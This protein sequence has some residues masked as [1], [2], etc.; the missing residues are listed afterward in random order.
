VPDPVSSASDAELR[1]HVERVLAPQYELEREI[2]RGGMGI[3]YRA[4][5]ARLKR[6]VAIKLLPPELAFRAE[7]RTRFLREAETAAQLSHPSIVPIHSVDEKEGLVFFVMAFVDGENLAHR[8]HARG[9]LPVEDVRRILREVAEALA[10]AHARGVVHRDIKPDNILLG[11]DGER[12]MVTDFGIARAVTEG[13]DSRLTA[14]GIAIGTPAFMSPEQSAGDREIDGRSDLYALGVVA[15]QMLTGQLP[16]TAASTPAMLVKHLS[17]RPTPVEQKRAG[18][19]PALAAAVMCLLE[20]APDDRFATATD[21]IAALDGDA[22]PP[23]R[24]S[25]ATAPPATAGMSPDQVALAGLPPLASWPS[26]PIE[27]RVELYREYDRRRAEALRTPGTGYDDVAPTPAEQQRWAAPVVHEFRRKVAPYVAVNAV[28]VG[29]SAFSNSDFTPITVIW[30][31]YMAF[32]Y[33]KL[34]Q[35]GYDWRDV[36]RQPRDKLFF[37]VVA[38]GLDDVKGLWNDEARARARAR[39]VLRR[40][41]A[42]APG[43]AP[44]AAPLTERDLAALGQGG[45]ADLARQAVADRDEVARL[46]AAMP[47]RE[48]ERVAELEPTARALADRVLALAVQAA[49]VARQPAPESLPALDAEIATLEAQANPLDTA[50]SEAR[51]RRLALLRRQRRAAAEA[52]RRRTEIREK[53]DACALALQNLRFD[54]L[55]L[56]TGTQSVEQVTLLAE[57]A[58][59]LARDVDDVLAAERTA[60]ATPP[61]AAPARS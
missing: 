13:G 41:M 8:I 43:L 3:V 37:D 40:G 59:S 6:A 58:M 12:A 54:V 1:A 24:S 4:R 51:V 34:W 23:R 26:R 7:I 27:E 29:V 30:T 9:P 11:V 38:E 57:K 10:Y 22:P 32:K 5:D 55:R 2:G 46:V 50:A 52:S 35:E 31:V 45:H 15:Y 33:A 28:L 21:L 18:I 44:A 61:G 49:E 39:R 17:E 19:P 48:R 56:K 36:F 60:R 47:P 25:G 42:P 20:K 16:F 53:L 14:T